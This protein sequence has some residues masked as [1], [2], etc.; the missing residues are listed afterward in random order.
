MG[1]FENLV[2]VIISNG[3]IYALLV[4]LMSN[5]KWFQLLKISNDLVS[6]QRF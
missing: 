2:V 4:E 1:K 5:Q 3:K 6:H